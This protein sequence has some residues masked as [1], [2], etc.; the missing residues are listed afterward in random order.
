M[1]AAY[2]FCDCKN[3]DP[4]LEERLPSLSHKKLSYLNNPPNM[5]TS[6]KKILTRNQ[7]SEY[8]LDESKRT[9]AVNLIIKKYRQHK[10]RNTMDTSYNKTTEN[11]K[12]NKNTNLILNNINNNTK[13]RNAF[14]LNEYLGQNDN[15]DNSKKLNSKGNKTH[16]HDNINATIFYIGEKE[17]NMKNGFGIK[18]MANEAKYI[19]YF[20]DNKS[21]GYGKFITDSDSYF[22]EF[23]NDQANGFGIYKHKNETIYIGYWENDSRENY[24]IEK[25]K[26]NSS[27]LGEFSG[28][29]KNG[30]GRYI[31]NNGSMYEGEWKDNKIDGY[32]IYLFSEQRIYI[33]EWKNNMKDGF[34]EFIWSDKI[35][36]GFYSNDKKHGFG[37]FYWKDL[38]KAFMGFWK[39]GK[40]SGF[41]KLI[42]RN[43]IIYGLW[44]NDK[45]EKTYNNENEAF[46]ELEKQ[47]LRGYEQI[48]LFSLDD[49]NNYCKD[50]G[51]WDEL[52]DYYNSI[53]I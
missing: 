31:F 35:Y 7:H 32:G 27:Y 24:G 8:S 34:G 16:T 48:F 37:I 40:Q 36:V 18:Y 47:K 33:G 26:D 2:N 6:N 39:N 49:V 5:I 9:N 14:E 29:E 41:G 38:N 46:E 17:N 21:E 1:G 50:D 28:G 12:P 19:G 43:K 45:L 4:R 22:G 42:H 25:W 10:L 13:S 30:I 51:L 3:N 20:K 52:L 11:N 15:C 53:E 44:E 23:M